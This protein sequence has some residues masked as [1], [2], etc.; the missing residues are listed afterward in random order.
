MIW[1]NNH[2]LQKIHTLT[3]VI[4]VPQI[5]FFLRDCSHLHALS[6]PQLLLISKKKFHLYILFYVIY[7]KK[8]PPTGLQDL[9]VHFIFDIFPLAHAHKV[10]IH[11]LGGWVFLVEQDTI[12]YVSWPIQNSKPLVCVRAC[13]RAHA[14]V[15]RFFCK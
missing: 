7:F 4:S 12:E 5:L 2:D 3:S 6:K 10:I 13:A 9:L 15:Q 14:R 1:W 11:K 8:F